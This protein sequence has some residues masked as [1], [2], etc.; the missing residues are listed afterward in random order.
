MVKKAVPLQPM[1]V[2]SG[3]EIYLQPL[4]NPIPEQE[5]ATKGG[6]DPVGNLHWIRLLAGPVTVGYPCWSSLF[7]K[8]CTP[9][10]APMW[11]QFTK[12]C[13]LEK[14]M[15]DCF[16]WVQPHTGTGEECEKLTP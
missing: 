3:A 14:F 1:E 12:N 15:K 5:D 4:K 16:L 8:D 6:S 2:H 9:W 13:S 11:E 7:L 10:E